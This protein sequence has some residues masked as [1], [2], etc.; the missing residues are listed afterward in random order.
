MIGRLQVRVPAEAA[1]EFSSPELTLCAGS[2]FSVRS[3]PLLQQWH[4]ID[5]GHA[6]ES[7]VSRLHLKTHTLLTK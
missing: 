5:A 1:G 7:A 3:T 4:V 6:V 2:Y